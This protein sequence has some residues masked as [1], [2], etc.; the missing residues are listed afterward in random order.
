MKALDTK[1]NIEETV[2]GAS[3][4]SYLI[5][6]TKTKKAGINSTNWIT[7]KDFKESFKWVDF[8]QAKLDLLIVEY[9]KGRS[10]SSTTKSA[11]TGLD[12]RDNQLMKILGNSREYQYLGP[13]CSKSCVRYHHYETH[14]AK[15]CDFYSGSLSEKYDNLNNKV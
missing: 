1:T 10:Q 3:G 12:S 11:F 5:T 8:D 15:D 13:R 6:R 9:A 4:S 2:I 7:E 14:H